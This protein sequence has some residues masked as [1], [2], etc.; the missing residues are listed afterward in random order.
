M[1][2]VAVSQRTLQWALARSGH[3]VENLG[4][5]FPKVRDWLSGATQPTLRELERLATV[6][7]TPLGFLFLSEPPNDSLP[8]RHFRT[9]A[10]QAAAA[11]PSPDLLETVQVMQR[12]QAWMR[13]HL[14]DQGQTPLPFVG[15]AATG[16]PPT[17]V[18]ALMRQVVGLS[19]EWATASPNW[20]EAMRTLLAAM[21]QAGILTV[22]NG[23]VGNNTHRR[24]EVSEFRGFV[25]A[26]EYAPLVFVNGRDAKAAQMFT[27]A[28]E[29]AHICFGAS[30]AFDLAGL[31]P[32]PDVTEEAC[33][34]VAAEFLV[35]EKSLREVWP[36]LPG[37]DE[38]FE[39]IAKRFRVSQL[40]AARRA[41]DLHLIS[42][43]RFFGFYNAWREAERTLTP[44]KG[45]SFYTNQN[46]RVGRRFGAEV[47][48]AAREGE[49]SYA[50]AYEL[51]GL[52]G[53]T[54]ERY[55]EHLGLGGQRR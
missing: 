10:D 31:Q 52:Y 41:L 5:R 46:Y 35:P 13:E 1:T 33:N 20:S 22:V 29:L 23:V 53:A 11:R 40:V 6:T 27:L 55:A 25:L 45:G 49:M 54:F 26:D 14:V 47:V 12:R 7:R 37:G 17:A 38:A 43:D 51:T 19:R 42:G 48:W 28:H 15:A 36:S 16:E 18:A 39:A 3:S 32:A 30:A 4:G 50:E 2:R 24:L 8:I 34:R 44:G 9:R 21:E